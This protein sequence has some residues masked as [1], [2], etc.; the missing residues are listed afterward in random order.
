MVDDAQ[1][2]A[3]RES[4]S[5]KPGIAARS[6]A[7]LQYA[8]DAYDATRPKVMGRHSAGAGFLKAMVRHAGL[9]TL[10]AFTSSRAEFDDFVRRIQGFGATEQKA[11]WV[12]HGRQSLLAEI[13]CLYLAGPGLDESAWERRFGDERRYS[14]CGVTHTVSS[15]RVM[16]ALGNLLIAPTQSWDAV[17]CTSRAVRTAVERLIQG[18]AAYLAERLGAAVRLPVQLPIIPLG[19]DCTIFDADA[20]RELR[21]AAL[22]RRLGLGPRDVVFLF[23]GRL[24][25]HAKAHPVP[26]FMA[27]EL[28]QQALAAEPGTAGHRIHLLM[29]GQAPNEKVERDIRDAGPRYCPN[30]PLHVL[31]GADPEI[32]ESAWSASDVFM[33]LSDNI[34][35]SFGLTPIEAM[36]AGL[37]TLVSDWDGYRDTAVD[38]ETGFRIATETPPAPAGFD[39]ALRH[40]TNMESYDRYIGAAS[41]ATAVDV[42]AAAEAMRRLAGSLELRRSLGEAG[43]YR[44]REI[45]DWRVVIG[46]YQELWSE[47]AQRRRSD[48]LLG[49]Q[50]PSDRA[51][52]VRPDP[53]DMFAGH[54]TRQLDASGVIRAVDARP[55]MRLEAVLAQSMNTYAGQY[56]LPVDALRRL[57]QRVSEGEL[58]V[59]DLMRGFAPHERRTLARTIAWLKKYDVLAF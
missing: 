43:R 23:F 46:Q 34:Q 22:R 9:D 31:D 53:F 20:T 37:P 36:A 28:A 26:M 58:H 3:T 42:R 49:S 48:K 47:L 55:L 27:A 33:S 10:Y 4:R 29:V 5:G 41:Q 21:R 54:A 19:V 39:V 50:A 51:P 13:G 32:A 45:Y 12:P 35:E 18:H 52:S 7:A 57:V 38:G 17:I 25:F 2:A 59:T 40:G 44:A 56:I 8:G 1:I 30:V 6:N 24:T 11:K 14:L 16:D 15:A